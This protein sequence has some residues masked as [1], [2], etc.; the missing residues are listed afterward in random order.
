MVVLDE[1]MKNKRMRGMGP[2][3]HGDKK[4]ICAASSS[5]NTVSF[6]CVHEFS[7]NVRAFFPAGDLRS[8][9]LMK[10]GQKRKDEQENGRG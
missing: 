8:V 7:V 2:A 10:G 4:Q 1:Q 9:A 5:R 6:S 3:L